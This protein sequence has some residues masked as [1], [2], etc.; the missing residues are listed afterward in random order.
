MSVSRSKG[1]DPRQTWDWKEITYNCIQDHPPAYV[2]GKPRKHTYTEKIDLNRLIHGLFAAAASF[3]EAKKPWTSDSLTT[4]PS[5]AKGRRNFTRSSL[6]YHVVRWSKISSF[7][8]CLHT[9]SHWMHE[10]H[11]VPCRVVFETK[12][13]YPAPRG[14]VLLLGLNDETIAIKWKESNLNPDHLEVRRFPRRLEGML[15][16]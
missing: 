7:V 8:G 15:L 2:G 4:L 11:R 14:I 1:P 6:N 13:A 16:L 12:R 5:C 10:F 9:S 3:I